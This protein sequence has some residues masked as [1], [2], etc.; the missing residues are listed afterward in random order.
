MSRLQRHLARAP[1]EQQFP[2]RMVTFQ[3]ENLDL[4]S[5]ESVHALAKKLLSAVPHLDVVISNAGTGSVIGLNWPQAIW[6]ILTEFVNATT[7]PTY[8][9]S[10]GGEVTRPQVSV[11]PSLEGRDKSSDPPPSLGLVFTSNVFGH[12]ILSHLLTPLL[13][14]SPDNGRM[15]FISSLEAYPNSFS[16]SDFQGLQ[17][18]TAYECSKRLT[19]LLVLTSDLPS[20]APFTNR[21]L[22]SPAS[23]PQPGIS[24]HDND[25]STT[26][27]SETTG[28]ALTDNTRPATNPRKPALY[29]TQPGI[30]AT[31]F[32]P[33]PWIVQCVMTLAF[34]IARLLGSP[35]H[36]VSAY[37]GACAPVWLALIQKEEI[38]DMETEAGKGKWGTSCDWLGRERVM[39]TGVSGW[40]SGGRVGEGR[41]VSARG[42][43]DVGV[44]TREKREEFEETAREC[45]KQMEE[46]RVFWER[47]MLE[48]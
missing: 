20:T 19:D 31:S 41:V 40:G 5:L 3:P 39:R 24:L 17:T 32:V 27:L 11:H 26:S 2:A 6:T 37:T 47:W 25:P 45:W 18:E 9:L 44:L 13:S 15:I 30:C 29:L 46:L 16:I 21:F 4:T 48:E 8:K 14:A 12:Y 28:I 36:T 34:Y 42:R 22:S 35:W 23:T 10:N 38:E 43:G 1:K 7:Y 33:L